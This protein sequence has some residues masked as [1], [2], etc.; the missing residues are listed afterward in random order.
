MKRLLY[1]ALA[2]ALTLTC[3]PAVA[4]DATLT[5]ADFAGKTMVCFNVPMEITPEIVEQTSGIKPS[6]I[7][8]VPTVSEG[9]AAL[10]SGRAEC[11]PMARFTAEYFTQA[12]ETLGFVDFAHPRNFFMITRA[13]DTE[14][15]GQLNEAIKALNEEGATLSLMDQFK[16]VSDTQGAATADYESAADAKTLYVGIS[17]DLPPLDYVAADGTP[18]GFNV[19]YTQK[20]AEK[21]GVKIEFVTIPSDAKFSA[22][23]SNKIDVFFWHMMPVDNEGIATTE[24]YIETSGAC[25]FVK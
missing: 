7:I 17:G 8:T 15:L 9:V 24:S 12:D 13:E 22:L 21:I 2:L 6:D 16:D 18:R 19:A 20:L 14:L 3:I 1:L 23:L 4:E 5:P 11:M 10:K 25:L